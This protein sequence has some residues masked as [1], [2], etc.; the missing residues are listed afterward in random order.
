[1]GL[2]NDRIWPWLLMSEKDTMLFFCFAWTVLVFHKN[3]FSNECEPVKYVICW[4]ALSVLTLS[5]IFADLCQQYD[6]SFSSYTCLSFSSTLR[7]CCYE[8]KLW[9]CLNSLRPSDA[10]MH[11]VNLLSLVQIMACRLVGASHYLNQC[12][13]IVNWTLGTNFSQIL[14]GIQTFSLKKLHL[15]RSSANWHLFCLS[16]NE[17]TQPICFT[18]QRWLL[19]WEIVCIL[20]WLKSAPNLPKLVIWFYK[21]CVRCL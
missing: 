1:M 2:V 19:K 21:N 16:L 5:H 20:Y 18:V 17:L 7:S 6:G 8:C 3:K 15:K 13:N 11:W 14:I 4:V 10:Y 12:W 9:F